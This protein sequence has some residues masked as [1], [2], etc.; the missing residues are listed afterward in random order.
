MLLGPLTTHFLIEKRPNSNL[1]SEE[2]S[3]KHEATPFIFGA[4]SEN[5]R[6]KNLE[7]NLC[8]FHRRQINVP[9]YAVCRILKPDGA[10]RPRFPDAAHV[11]VAHG[12]RHAPE[13][14]FNQGAHLGLFPVPVFLSLRQGAVS[15]AFSVYLQLHQSDILVDFGMRGFPAVRHAAVFHLGRKQVEKL[16][17]C[18]RLCCTM[19]AAAVS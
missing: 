15:L 13:N 1:I 19:P 5:G 10:L 8:F 18:R 6:K 4:F 11:H 3:A 14:V 2:T 16:P 9:A 17:F 7:L 12:I